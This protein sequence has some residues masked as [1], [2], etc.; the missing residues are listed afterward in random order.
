MNVL[1]LCMLTTRH[2]SVLLRASR[3][4]ADAKLGKHFTVPSTDHTEFYHTEPYMLLWRAIWMDGCCGAQE[5]TAIEGSG[6]GFIRVASTNA[7]IAQPCRGSGSYLHCAVQY[8]KPRTRCCASGS[9]KHTARLAGAAPPPP[10]KHTNT[11]ISLTESVS[12]FSATKCRVVDFVSRN[13][14]ILF[15]FCRHTRQVMFTWVRSS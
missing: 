5:K 9:I 14:T 4:K 11:D 7:S 1:Y 3:I 8:A 13:L 2:G 6:I 10:H 12:L 15:C